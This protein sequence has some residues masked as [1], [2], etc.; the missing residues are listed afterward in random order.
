MLRHG[1]VLKNLTVPV[2]AGLLTDVDSY[3]EALTAYRKATPTR[4][5]RYSRQRHS[6]RSKTRRRWRTTLTRTNQS[7]TR[8]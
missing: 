8:S 4:L 6:L 1:N 7:G 5:C 2:S 3:F